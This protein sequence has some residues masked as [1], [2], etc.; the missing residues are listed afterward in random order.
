LCEHSIIEEGTKKKTLV[1]IFDRVWSAGFPARYEATL[2]A[3]LTDAEGSY[4][5]RVEFVHVST[6]RLLAEAELKEAIVLQNRLAFHE[7]I[8]KIEPAIVDQPGLYEYRLYANGAYLGRATL[9]ARL[10]SEATEEGPHDTS[11]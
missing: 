4:R 7:V 11:A 8:I 6:D 2:Y 10:S 9:N 1:G 5:L 3:R